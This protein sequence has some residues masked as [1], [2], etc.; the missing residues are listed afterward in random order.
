[1]ARLR[2]TR[3]RRD[4]TR[5]KALLDR[6]EV[7]ARDPAVNLLPV[8]IELVRHRASLGEIVNRLRNIWGSYVERPVF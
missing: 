8:T 6:L 2:A 5:V 4:A 7:E 3:A 1:V